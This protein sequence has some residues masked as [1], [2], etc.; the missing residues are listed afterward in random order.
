MLAC[1]AVPEHH[2]LGQQRQSVSLSNS[3]QYQGAGDSSKLSLS[4]VAS[5]NVSR[6]PSLLPTRQP[7]RQCPY[8]QNMKYHTVN[9][10][11]VERQLTLSDFNILPL[12]VAQ[13]E[14]PTVDHW[15]AHPVRVL[16]RIRKRP[17]A[18][19]ISI[20]KRPCLDPHSQ[21]SVGLA[22]LPIRASMS[23]PAFSNVR[24]SC[25]ILHN[26]ASMS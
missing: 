18:A 20:P 8:R 9:V 11:L 22:N 10:S 7:S 26:R 23:C 16:T 2:N 1:A 6:K 14:R 5:C 3:R 19:R 12:S 15:P 21:T 4:V 24:G 13:Y 17:W 25:A